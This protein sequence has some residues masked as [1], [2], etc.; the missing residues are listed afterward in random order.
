MRCADP[1]L[2]TRMAHLLRLRGDGRYL[3]LACGTGNYTISLAAR[4]GKWTGLD[5]ALT[6]IEQARAKSDQV[7]WEVG[8]AEEMRA[9]DGTYDG[10]LCTLAL[11][12]FSDLNAAFHEVRRVIREGRFVMFTSSPEQ[13]RG[14]WLNAYFP[15][16]M[17]RSIAKMPA[18]EAVESA[19]KRSGFRRV[20]LEL[21]VVQSD[22]RD[23]FL[24]CSKHRPDLYLSEQA[25]VGMSTFRVLADADEIRTGCERLADDLR[26]GQFA[27]VLARYEH[28]LGDYVF[29]SAST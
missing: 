4:G 23:G 29:V 6:M 24:F 22:L 27:E 10:V 17:A 16:A 5:I 19:C 26:T 1:Y 21:Y 18:V 25:R 13:M 8:R 3:D 11:H 20:D 15:T 14:Y 7:H 9:A 28:M 2:A 12:H